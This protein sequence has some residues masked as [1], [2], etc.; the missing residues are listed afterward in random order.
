MKSMHL[1]V[2]S[3]VWSTGKGMPRGKLC[4]QNSPNLMNTCP[5][6]IQEGSPSL[7]GTSS[8]FV[9]YSGRVSFF[10]T[11]VIQPQL[12]QHYSPGWVERGPA[13]RVPKIELKVESCLLMVLVLRPLSMPSCRKSKTCLRLGCLVETPWSVHQWENFFHIRL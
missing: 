10:W 6:N 7:K 2:S 12:M 9:R 8:A 13:L 4:H 11:E 1:L 3:L 5:K